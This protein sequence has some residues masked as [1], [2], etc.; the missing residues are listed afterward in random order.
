MT[1][2]SEFGSFFH[3]DP[4]A[5]LVHLASLASL[6]SSGGEPWLRPG[7][8][9]T[10]SGR[11]ALRAI[12]AQGRSRG[13]R[14]IYA[15]SYY[16]HAVLDDLAGDIDVRMYP[17]APFGDATPLLLAPD[18]AAIVPEYF[19]LRAEVEV[20]GGSVLLDRSHD[21][22]ADWSYARAPDYVFASLRKTLPVPDGGLVR[23]LTGQALTPALAPTPG[24]A[25]AAA[26]MA[27]AMSMKAA[28]LAGAQ[29]DKATFLALAGEAEGNLRSDAEISGPSMLTRVL[30]PALD[31]G[32]MRQRRRDNLA[33]LAARM[34]GL[35]ARLQW[36]ETPAYGI[37]LCADAPQRDRIRQR[38][39]A[40]DVYPAV[41]WPM[42][43]PAATEDNRRLS[44]RILVV[45]ADHRY[46]PRDIERLAEII[47]DVAT[48]PDTSDEDR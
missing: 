43:W 33:L 8:L 32:R 23:P 41:L 47:L 21:L 7:D 26:G 15:P 24:H 29:V 10:G 35:P 19:G 42:T 48:N 31:L 2:A 5:P 20:Q 3:L 45:H 40:R 18:E 4:A 13:W 38:L 37:L 14:R 6:A 9:L 1:P 44:G 30:A 27:A 34:A 11:D 25:R 22:L 16:C 36:Q 12:V 28:Y 17:H 46:G 39:I